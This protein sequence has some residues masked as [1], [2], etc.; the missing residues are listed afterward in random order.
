[1]NGHSIAVNNLARMVNQARMVNGDQTIATQ[2]TAYKI[3]A[4]SL[5]SLVFLIYTPRQNPV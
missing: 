2:S 1:M 3:F 5:V 4:K